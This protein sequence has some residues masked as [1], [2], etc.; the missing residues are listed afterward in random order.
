MTSLFLSISSFFY[1]TLLIIVYFSKKRIDT[2]EN[3]I[4]KFLLWISVFGALFEILCFP[5]AHFYG[6]YT[7][8]SMVILKGY[9]FYL[10]IWMLLFT[11]YV[12]SISNEHYDK[13]DKNFEAF[14]KKLVFVAST[15][16][17]ILGILVV[18]LPMELYYDGTSSYT[19]GPSVDVVFILSG[20][21]LFLWAFSFVKNMKR[22]NK[23]KFIPVLA[24]IILGTASILIQNYNPSLILSCFTQTLV[25]FI[26]YFTISNPD[27][28]LMREL[29]KN[30][31][32]IEKTNDDT[33]KF[34]FRMTQDLKSYIKQLQHTSSKLETIND[35][36]EM[37]IEIVNINNSV[38][39]LEYVFNNALNISS[40]T[41]KKIKIY[42]NKYNAINLFNEICYRS[43]KEMNEKVRFNISIG[44]TIPNFL[45][46]DSI[47]LK[48]A[49]SSIM[50]N[51]IDSTKKGFIDF[52]VT[53]VIKH[54]ACRL[55]IQVEDSGKGMSIEE[56]NQI[57]SL[58][59]EDMQDIDIDRLEEKNISLKAV[60]KLI[61]LLGGSLMVKSE[62]EAGTSITIVLDQKIVEAEEAE[63]SKRLEN[64][65]KSLQTKTNV[66]VIDENEQLTNKI[67]SILERE[68]I[69]VSLALCGQDGL[70]KIMS[71]N[72]YD[73]II[74]DDE[75]TDM[76]GLMA[77]KELKQNKKFNIPTI[78]MIDDRKEFIKLHYIKDGF[79]DTII[80]S[81]LD[82]EMK[83][84]IK[85]FN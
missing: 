9:L 45:Y 17:V 71:K 58:T 10:I 24:L 20:I 26:M 5:A 66:L 72:K 64:Y 15:V 75:L 48:Q 22:I 31:K 68:N 21:C 19:H 78:V 53:S 73:F 18:V 7:N 82:E 30:K 54:N 69:E 4:Y 28:Q 42:E 39:Q 41:T 79:A 25:T 14:L 37:K 63:I 43:K 33:S 62:E 81:E 83:R 76:S 6:E 59:S 61:T 1:I 77:L 11:F 2:L 38:N 32:L 67:T 56:V 16:F 27:V 3:K 52:S 46:G 13:N 49:I 12:I 55:I 74:I 23:R 34:I 85:R 29:Y 84:I 44:D 35:I 40:M 70:E 47:K 36:D 60:K 80:K 57:L 8:I 65:E 51:S 50:K